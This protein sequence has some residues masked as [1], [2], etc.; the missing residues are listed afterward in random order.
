[1]TSV[2]PEVM[3]SVSGSASCQSNTRMHGAPRATT[4]PATAAR[5]GTRRPVRVLHPASHA[6]AGRMVIA[7]RMA[8]VCA[9]LE[10]M[11]ACEASH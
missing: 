2:A 11:A 4:G 1:M 8:D 9:E 6:E 3:G 7:G 5:R 10:R